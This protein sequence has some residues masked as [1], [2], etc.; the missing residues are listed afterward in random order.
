MLTYETAGDPVSGLK[1]TRK[2]TEKIAEE[3]GN[4]GIRVS[5]KTVAKL[6][7]EMGFSLRANQKKLSRSSV[8]PE[9]RNEQFIYIA[10][11]RQRFA[12]KGAIIVSIDTKKKNWLV[13]LRMMGRYGPT[14]L[15]WLMITTFVHKPKG[16]Q[17]LTVSM[18]RWPTAVRYLSA[19][20]VIL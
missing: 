11:Q 7:K 2:T 10:D 12:D 6:L 14:R 8:S 4:L 3:L 13:I 5:L 9:E 19:S 15:R 20:L 1:W 17:S 18:T 16:L